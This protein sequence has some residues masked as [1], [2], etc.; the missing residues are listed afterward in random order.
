MW[1]CCLLLF[2]F[3]PMDVFSMWPSTTHSEAKQ[4]ELRVFVRL[5]KVQIKSGLIVFSLLDKQ[6]QISSRRH[7]GIAC[8]QT[9][10]IPQTKKNLLSLSSL[11]RTWTPHVLWCCRLRPQQRGVRFWHGLFRLVALIHWKLERDIF[12]NIKYFF[13]RKCCSHIYSTLIVSEKLQCSCNF[14][15]QNEAHGGN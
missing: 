7:G 5:N 6:L 8:P 12:F 14:D 9:R 1:N 13:M 4:E 15:I 2:Y 3:R 11:R 10:F